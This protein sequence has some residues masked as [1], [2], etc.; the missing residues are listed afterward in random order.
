MNP[1][2]FWIESEEF[3]LFL[4]VAQEAVDLLLAPEEN[5][6]LALVQ[7]KLNEMGGRYNHFI[8]QLTEFKINELKKTISDFDTLEK[9]VIAFVK[10]VEDLAVK[11]YPQLMKIY[12]N[13]RDQTRNFSLDEKDFFKN[14]KG[15]FFKNFFKLFY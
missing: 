9:E 1:F 12:F 4:Q 3:R 11:Q 7:K 5:K 13:Y 14:N 15:W 2:I 8:F 6:S 10:Q